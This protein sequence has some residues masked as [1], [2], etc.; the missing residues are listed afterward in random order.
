MIKHKNK[1][2]LKSKAAG[3]REAGRPRGAIGTKNAFARDEI[4][5]QFRCSSGFNKTVAALIDTGNYKSKSDILHEALQLL[6][7]RK[8]PGTFYHINRIQ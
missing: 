3:G 7:V 2:L 8:L 1:A 6:A 4:C 5:T